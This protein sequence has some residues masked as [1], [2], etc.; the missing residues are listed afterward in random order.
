MRPWQRFDTAEAAASAEGEPV[1]AR[2]ELHAAPDGETVEIAGRRVPLEME[3]PSSIASMMAEQNPFWRDMKRFFVGDLAR[4]VRI[5]H[6]SRGEEAKAAGRRE[7]VLV[8]QRLA[9][10]RIGPRFVAAP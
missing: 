5:Q 2:L 7:P 3:P 1:R 6:Q 8:R 10:V 4:R 9:A